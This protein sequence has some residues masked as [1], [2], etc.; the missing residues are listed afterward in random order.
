[1]KEVVLCFD[2]DE[3]GHNAALR[4]LD[5]LLTAE[6]AVRVAMVPAPHDPDSYIKAHGA[7]AF[8]KVIQEA[9]GFFDY[10]LKRLCSL[11][12]LQSDKGRLTVLRDM[13]D[14]V[15]KTR[16]YVLIDNYAQ[17][18]ALRL[19]VRTEAVRAEFQ[20]FASRHQPQSPAS[21]A[22]METGEQTIAPPSAD[23]EWLLK[24]LF[25]H[26]ELIEW[27]MANLK[28]DWVSHPVVR[29][30]I[31]RR[32]AAHRDGSWTTMGAFLEQLPDALARNL[33]TEAATV[34]R[35]LSNPAQMMTDVTTKLRNQ[36]LDAAMA[37]LLNK[38][39]QPDLPETE[40][41]QAARER[42]ELRLLKKISFPP[43]KGS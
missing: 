34:E 21:D 33:V 22:E 4:S 13:A 28:L 29:E 15:N 32:L 30:I 12:D 31:A 25:C 2:S 38:I 8:Q 6:L 24:L 10:H 19:G 20:K 23:Q 1:V 40:R 5:H 42:E 17:K 39:G 7:G 9:E 26:E 14:A 18:T 27:P 37:A 35:S 3:A 41:D 16:N 36:F 43:C 11:N